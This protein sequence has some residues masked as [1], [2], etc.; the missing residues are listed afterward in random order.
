[1]AIVQKG[2]PFTAG[3]NGAVLEAGHGKAKINGIVVTLNELRYPTEAPV[4]S[5]VTINASAL[6]A[7]PN[8]NVDTRT[9]VETQAVTGTVTISGDVTGTVSNTLGNSIGIS[10]P[11][12][13]TI[14]P[15]GS[16]TAFAIQGAINSNGAVS[17]PGTVDTSSGNV[18]A[19]SGEGSIKINNSIIPLGEVDFPFTIPQNSSL[20]VL[21]GSILFHQ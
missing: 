21:G 6:T 4:T 1:M 14:E 10:V 17:T 5:S 9:S 13:T 7:T 20:E 11:M 16:S 19:V 12:G 15:L 18:F 3:A 2:T 8:L